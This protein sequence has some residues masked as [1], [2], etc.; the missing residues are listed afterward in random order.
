[1][2]ALAHNRTLRLDRIK[3][4]YLLPVAGSWREDLDQL[5]V[6]VQLMGRLVKDYEAS[7]DDLAD[8]TSADG[9]TRRIV[10]RVTSGYWLMRE[11]LG[12]GPNAVVVS[13]PAVRDLARQQLA[14]ALAAYQ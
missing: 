10:R 8:E 14:A 4:M 13:P 1:M 2:P 12:W 6:E 7:E 11:L 9:S 3:H 5:V